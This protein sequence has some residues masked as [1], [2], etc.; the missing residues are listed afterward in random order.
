MENKMDIHI[1]APRALEAHY[2]VLPKRCR[3]F[4]GEFQK[5][6]DAMQYGLANC[7]D[8][9]RIFLQKTFVWCEP[10]N[11]E[12]I[13]VGPRHMLQDLPHVDKEEIRRRIEYGA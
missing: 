10:L 11:I 9:F 2:R 6:D 8:G 7:P 4:Q 1:Y 5:V 12:V 3:K 13:K